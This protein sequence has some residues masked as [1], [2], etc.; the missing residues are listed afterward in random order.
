MTPIGP[1][2]GLHAKRVRRAE[3]GSGI[4][5]TVSAAEQARRQCMLRKAIASVWLR[6]RLVPQPQVELIP[7]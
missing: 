5:A 2:K 4:D 1:R 6:L 7:S 3:L